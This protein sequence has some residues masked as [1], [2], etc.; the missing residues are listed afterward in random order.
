VRSLFVVA[1]LL[2]LFIRFKLN[3]EKILLEYDDAI[4]LLAA[5]GHERE[6]AQISSTESYPIG[7][8]VPAGEW[9]RLVEPEPGRGLRQVA[10][11][12]SVYDIHPPLYFWALH[13]W[14]SLFGTSLPALQGFNL[15]LELLI[16]GVLVWVG[17][18]VF[19]SLSAGL[20]LGATW[21]LSPIAIKT[22]FW[23]R[24]YTFL[25]LVLLS[26]SICFQLD[27]PSFRSFTQRRSP[28][29]QVFTVFIFFA[30]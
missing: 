14:V 5:T 2:G 1:V 23:V 10:S 27:G 16:L 22:A 13:G 18:Q 12:L 19:G 17:C 7:T 30:E 6:Y 11:D 8:W 15:F 24:Q 4:T 9:Q 25:G 26:F 3:S 20:L 28:S 29:W 21:F